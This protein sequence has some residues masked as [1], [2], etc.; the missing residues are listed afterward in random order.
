MHRNAMHS[1]PATVYGDIEE[2]RAGIDW[3]SCSL[4]G[5][6]RDRAT[7]QNECIH[8][9]A[10]I[11]DEGHQ[12][13]AMGMLGYK[14]VQVGGSFT[15]Q[16]ED[17]TYCQLAGVYA[18]RYFKRIAR[19]DLQISRLDLA[20]TVKF[21]LMPASLGEDAYQAALDADK[22]LSGGRHRRLWYM[23]G[24]DG[25]YTLY[26]GS[27]KSEERARLY[28]KEVQSETPDYARC[29]RYETV[30][31]N[32]RAMA[33]FESL[34]AVD[35]LYASTLCG[36]LVGTWFGNRGV[37]CPWLSAETASIRPIN[38]ENPSDAAKKLKWLRTQV[39]PALR[40]LIEHG[41]EEDALIA[42]KLREP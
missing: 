39:Q 34:F 18:Q 21:R 17:S 14:G 10:E 35:E 15:G 16:R 37:L 19:P 13:R 4:P 9:L 28:N 8:V 12:T 42:L 24:S 7:W 1:R 36:I 20:V 26:I 23:S 29:W 38:K 11:S 27:P 40:W 3:L 6:T 2:V 30:Y 22:N 32:D 25:G 31:R 5:E 33:V 41:F